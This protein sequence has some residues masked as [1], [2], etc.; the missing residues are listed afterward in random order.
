M[1]TSTRFYEHGRRFL[2]GRA[3]LPKPT[4]GPLPWRALPSVGSLVVVTPRRC[5]CVCVKGEGGCCRD[6]DLGREKTNK[7]HH[8]S[9]YF[10]S[11][12][13][14]WGAESAARWIIFF[15]PDTNESRVEFLPIPY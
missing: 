6:F 15:I 3:G 7:R 9:L 13:P 4:P 8:H 5:V 12:R 2:R 14:H 10:D 1:A 11:F